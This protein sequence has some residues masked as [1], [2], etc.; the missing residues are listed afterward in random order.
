VLI[1]FRSGDEVLWCHIQ[2]IMCS[3]IPLPPLSW[4]GLSAKRLHERIQPAFKT[5]Y[6]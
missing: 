1:F 4:S 6:A 3:D 5:G 2:L